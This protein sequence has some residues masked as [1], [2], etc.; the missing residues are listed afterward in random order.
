VTVL[1]DKA[2]VKGL[3]LQNHIFVLPNTVGWVG[4]PG[5]S[6]HMCIVFLTK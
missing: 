2:Q 3:N 5:V 4:L 1:V 6:L